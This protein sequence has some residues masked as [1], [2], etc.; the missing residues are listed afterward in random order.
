MKDL[1]SR[2]WSY[3]SSATFAVIILILIAVISILGTVIPQNENPDTY[4][5]LYGEVFAG[6]FNTLGLTALFGTA[7]FKLLLTV[8]GISL[9][10]ASSKRLIEAFAGRRSTYKWGSFLAHLSVLIIYLGVLYGN[11]AGF[12]TYVNIEKG[13]AYFQH[14]LAAYIQI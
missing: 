13:K 7:F 14:D 9:L 8:L 11:L 6:L 3:I 1:M 5:K 10:A 4:L 2:T 12:S